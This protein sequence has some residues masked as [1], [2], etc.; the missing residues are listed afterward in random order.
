MTPQQIDGTPAIPAIFRGHKDSGF[1]VRA[2]GLRNGKNP[3]KLLAGNL[4]PEKIPY[5]CI[6]VV[7]D[8]ARMNKAVA[9]ARGDWHYSD[10]DTE[11]L[12][13][14]RRGR[15]ALLFDL[16]N[17]G[18]SYSVNVFSEFYSWIEST[19]L[20]ARKCFWLAQ[21][22]AIGGAA[23]EQHGARADLVN[24]QSYDYFIKIV[25]WLF[26]PANPK[27]VLGAA[28]ESYIARL[29]DPDR[30]DKLLLCLNATARLSRV[31]TVAALH[32]HRLLSDSLVSFPGPTYAK[33][34]VPAEEVTRFIDQHSPLDHL[35]PAVDAVLTMA[36]L[37]VDSFEEQGNALVTKIDPTPYE[38]TMFS[39]VTESDFSDGRIQRV[40]EKV[41]KAYCMGHPAIVVGNP[42][43]VQFMTDLGFADWSETLDRSVEAVSDPVSRFE[44][45]I[46][47]TLRQIAAI[48]EN[49]TNW[50]ARVAE[51]SAFNVRHAASGNFLESY[52]RQVDQPLLA[53]LEAALVG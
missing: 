22:R 47:E 2:M 48:R 7:R 33:R 1:F 14:V 37:R 3:I 35:R 6:I 45:T 53:Q 44:M 27:R 42:N 34:G 43:S 25:A 12:D 19:A 50:L 30:K 26:S 13:D 4:R 18:P 10:L 32:H 41:A 28:A 49:K 8:Y 11:I 17:E 52:V 36:E 23:K 20:P 29:I 38:R 21:N 51:A 39:L 46:Q 24:F 15:C 9:Q 16:S 31:L 5:L 40:T